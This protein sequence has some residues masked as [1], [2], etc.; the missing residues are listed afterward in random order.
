MTLRHDIHTGTV[1]GFVATFG[2]GATGIFVCLLSGVPPFVIVCGRFAVALIMVAGLFV[3]YPKTIHEFYATMRSTVSW[4]LSLLIVAY[5]MFSVFAFQYASISIV[6]L[7]ISIS[8]VFVIFIDSFSN[9][10]LN[11]FQKTSLI[12][13]F[14]GAANIIMPSAFDF[15]VS[16]SYIGIV[17]ALGG[18]CV[19]A[20]YALLY[21]H[22]ST[23]NLAPN[24]LV[25]GVQTAIFGFSL[26]TFIVI[27]QFG[28][29]H[30]ELSKL[31]EKNLVLLLELGFVSTVVP[32]VSYSIAASRIE[33]ILL[34]T[35]RSSTPIVAAV[36]SFIILDE[37][38]KAEFY[39]G[40]PFILGAVLLQTIDGLRTAGPPQ[41]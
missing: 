15:Q 28:N 32:S 2:W 30:T 23:Q 21:R 11:N 40:A 39:F 7:L 20:L 33:P 18:A 8:P 31:T 9:K 38:P 36:L 37:I 4:T 12:C 26:S 6:S 17:L 22:L 34:T 14:S 10:R 1:A 3:L 5:Y 41:T 24:P 27:C 13:A 25:V 19:M 29:L 35:I 16:N